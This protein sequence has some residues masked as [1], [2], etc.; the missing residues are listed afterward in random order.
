[1]HLGFEG[2]PLSP[3]YANFRVQAR[4]FVLESLY[5]LPYAFVDDNGTFILRVFTKV[6]KIYR[7]I[8]QRGD[9]S[10][11]FLFEEVAIERGV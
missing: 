6:A 1:M 3:Q 10:H 11:R 9:R 8:I 2:I 5:I 7:G 4:N